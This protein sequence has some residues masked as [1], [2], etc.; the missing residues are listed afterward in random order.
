MTLALDCLRYYMEMKVAFDNLKRE[1]PEKGYDELRKMA[2]DMPEVRKYRVNFGPELF[3]NSKFTTLSFNIQSLLRCDKPSRALH[4][5][6]LLECMDLYW[7]ADISKF[8]STFANCLKYIYKLIR[9]FVPFASKLPE[10]PFS[11][12]NFKGKKGEDESEFKN[13]SI[14][15]PA[16]KPKVFDEFKNFM[17]DVFGVELKD[18]FFLKIPKFICYI[19]FAIAGIVG[20]VYQNDKYHKESYCKRILNFLK[21]CAS[22]YKNAKTVWEAFDQ[23]KGFIAEMIGL[24]VMKPQD[25]EKALFISNI[26]EVSD[27]MKKTQ[28]MILKTPQKILSIENNMNLINKGMDEVSK[29]FL[30]ACTIDANLANC[31]TQLEELRRRCDDLRELHKNV[32]SSCGFKQQPVVIYLWGPSGMGKSKM[33]SEIVE[34]LGLA[35][36]RHLEEFMYQDSNYFNGYCYQPVTRF[37]EFSND[38]EG[39]DHATFQLLA[40]CAA[41]QVERADLS[42]KGIPYCSR[43]II[44][45][46]N[47]G[48]IAN[49]PRVV[50][51]EAINRRKDINVAV[52][53][54]KIA[55]FKALYGS[56]PPDDSVI[57]Q[58][59]WSHVDLRRQ[60]ALDQSSHLEG[61]KTTVEAIVEEALKIEKI[62][63]A[64]FRK[65]VAKGVK[66][67]EEHTKFKNQ[68]NEP[69]PFDN[70]V[71]ELISDYFTTIFVV[72]KSRT[73]GDVIGYFQKEYPDSIKYEPG[74]IVGH[75]T[76]YLCNASR[77]N[78]N[79]IF[80]IVNKF[81]RMFSECNSTLSIFVAEEIFPYIKKD[82]QLYIERNIAFVLLK[83]IAG[84][85]Y[86]SI[87][88][89]ASITS[90]FAFPWKKQINNHKRKQ[91]EANFTPYQ[92]ELGNEE[93]EDPE[94]EP[95]RFIRIRSEKLTM[96]EVVQ[97]LYVMPRAKFLDYVRFF[98]HFKFESNIEHPGPRVVDLIAAV[99]DNNNIEISLN[100]TNFANSGN[101]KFY[102][103]AKDISIMNMRTNVPDMD[104]FVTCTRDEVFVD[105]YIK[106]PAEEMD[107]TDFLRGECEASWHEYL[108]MMQAY[109]KIFGIQRSFDDWGFLGKS[110]LSFAGLATLLL[111]AGQMML[112]M[113]LIEQH[114]QQHNKY[115][116]YAEGD[117]DLKRESWIC[118]DENGKVLKVMKGKNPV[119]N[120]RGCTQNEY[121]EKFGE[122]PWGDEWE[123]FHPKKRLL[124]LKKKPL[125]KRFTDFLSGDSDF[126]NQNRGTALKMFLKDEPSE[127][128][129]DIY[130][131]NDVMSE[132]E[133][134]AC[135]DESVI[136]L[137]TSLTKSMVYLIDEN[138]Q[139]ACHGIMLKGNIGITVSHAISGNSSF[140]IETRERKQFK[141]TPV[142]RLLGFDLVV[143]RVD[144]K[145]FPTYKNIMKHMQNS[146]HAK[147]YN[148]QRCVLVTPV[149]RSDIVKFRYCALSNYNEMEEKQSIEAGVEYSGAFS[150]YDTVLP[151]GTTGGDCGSLLL[152]EDACVQHKFIGIHKSA[153]LFLGTACPVFEDWF[154]FHSEKKPDLIQAFEYQKCKVMDKQEWIPYGDH[155][156]VVGELEYKQP[157]SKKTDIMRCPLETD[158]YGSNFE[159]SLVWDK[160]KR[161]P[162]EGETLED[163][164]LDKWDFY[165]PQPEPRILD[166]IEDE[167]FEF[168]AETFQSHRVGI[169][170]WSMLQAINHDTSCVK[171][172]KINLSSSCGYPYKYEGHTSK[173]R[174]F[175]FDEDRNLWD[176]SAENGKRLK[177]NIDQLETACF[178]NIKTAVVFT[179]TLKNEPV[180]LKKIYETPKPRGFVASPVDFLLLYRMYFGG[181]IAKIVE[182]NEFFPFKVG[183]DPQ[184]TGWDLMLRDLLKI[185]T[186]GH[187][188]DTKNWDAH[189]NTY[190]MDS[191]YRIYARLYERFDPSC[192]DS[193]SKIR[194]GIYKHIQ[195]PIVAIRKMMVMFPGGQIS[196]QPGTTIDNSIINIMYSFYCYIRILG[197]NKPIADFFR[198]VRPCSFGDDKITVVAPKMK[199]VFT[200]TECARIMEE[201]LSIELTDANKSKELRNYYP[202]RTMN[203]LKRE[204]INVNSIRMGRCIPKVFDKMLNWMHSRSKH[205]FCET[206]GRF[207]ND[208]DVVEATAESY[209]NEIWMY[210]KKE[211][212]WAREHCKDV[213]ANMGSSY[214]F[215]T[216]QEMIASKGLAILQKNEDDLEYQLTNF[217]FQ[218]QT[219]NMSVSTLAPGAEGSSFEN[220][221]PTA[222]SPV[223]AMGTPGV[224]PELQQ[225]GTTATGNLDPQLYNL[226]IPIATPSLSTLSMPGAVIYMVKISPRNHP[227]TAYLSPMYNTWGGGFIY[228]V[229]PCGTF[230]HAG[231][232]AIA[233]VPPNIKIETLTTP[234]DFA[235]YKVKYIDVRDQGIE[236]MTGQDER[237]ILFHWNNTL[238]E[239]DVNQ[240]GGTFVIYPVSRMV[241]SSDL[242]NISIVV[243]VTPAPDFCFMQLRTPSS[244][245]ATLG[246]NSSLINEYCDFTLPSNRRLPISRKGTD[247][248]LVFLDKSVVLANYQQAIHSG[249]DR[250]KEWTLYP[251]CRNMYPTPPYQLNDLCINGAGAKVGFLTFDSK[252]ATTWYPGTIS[253]GFKY[254]GTTEVPQVWEMNNGIPRIMLAS[255]TVTFVKGLGFVNAYGNKPLVKPEGVMETN[256]IAVPN[257]ESLVV[258]ANSTFDGDSQFATYCL[259]PYSVTEFLLDYYDQL[260]WPT[261]SALVF[262][263]HSRL[264]Q[265]PVT[266]VKLYKSGIFT[267]I[268]RNAIEINHLSDFYFR[269]SNTVPASSGWPVADNRA[270][271]NLL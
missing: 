194:W 25:K 243:F 167:M 58:K 80:E 271:A 134:Q 33:A 27:L 132:L 114:I 30:K 59:D 17:Q 16:T 189:L 266:Y 261:D 91:T 183:I 234:Q 84:N 209:L 151:I 46:S 144:D 129:I 116:R 53:S 31:K 206:P 141:A 213:V 264:T 215:P 37:E 192:K 120:T 70:K 44:I 38:K 60:R 227:F 1:F 176:F 67:Y 93:D 187:D 265:A 263:V 86:K 100:R 182:F 256:N 48:Y 68:A 235:P 104:K 257:G 160:D 2:E 148:K 71:D 267:T 175:E 214:H 258:F 32:I 112:S 155:S 219:S 47:Q 29:L 83:N 76:N 174:F 14:F 152:L 13:Q 66:F 11:F 254:L 202:L 157:I 20:L 241:T 162:L 199:D 94:D 54:E 78:H 208:V 128:D 137:A 109:F 55:E 10:N 61:E 23:C 169:Q 218:C 171:S 238:G 252:E 253:P 221:G 57:Y 63:A 18:N 268:A 211:Y 108:F 89:N 229:K 124:D 99:Y 153:S 110:I 102:L 36:D 130:R 123:A 101:V 97:A 142:T 223:P 255:E 138:D 103:H 259:C 43:Y 149:F 145:Q 212:E 119:K 178:K 200:L 232:F 173:Q 7:I 195:N 105:D 233:V 5:I 12:L 81:G 50:E 6:M 172:K 73:F 51:P 216:F 248:R 69:N 244:L 163:V 52:F 247:E 121:Y 166:H 177:Q 8:G 143:F 96:A 196:G 245:P 127:A 230:L 64:V 87:M 236:G 165:H 82:R 225:M 26:E 191:L 198:N 156:Y 3:A 154:G 98:R 197:K 118:Y 262:S 250:Y 85:D 24:E 72:P 201:D 28:E 158:R 39:K 249:Y 45:T 224:P 42:G 117:D 203:F 126:Q 133:L 180:E 222:A 113:G 19:I 185:G 139:M 74:V 184:S 251:Y 106:I 179:G 260:D 111:S 239:L 161:N 75:E 41:Y 186:H 246:Q 35:E 217:E 22:F 193:H 34:K 56:I 95:E 40:S 131:K 115:V 190:F 159:P 92:D 122:Y 164:A 269:Y 136:E 205:V 207:G 228:E 140:I 125:L 77:S 65:S 90:C 9:A 181:V 220:A 62:R 49:S 240:I 237:N 88:E 147:I 270:R 79:E 146:E 168:I 210:G 21:D 150:G 170:K 204:T 231:L 15:M 188:E 242:K 226:R 107:E 135:V 4:V